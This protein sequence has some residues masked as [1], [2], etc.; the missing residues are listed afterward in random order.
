VGWND[1]ITQETLNKFR[2]CSFRTLR[3]IRVKFGG[4][5]KNLND[6]VFYNRHV[7]PKIPTTAN[8]KALQKYLRD[9][10]EDSISHKGDIKILI[11]AILHGYDVHQGVT[12][13]STD[14]FLT[15]HTNKGTI[16]EAIVKFYPDHPGFEIKGLD[17]IV[18]QTTFTNF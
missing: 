2:G 4:L 6:P 18:I 14:H 13:R 1:E 9:E 16:Q 3:S 10:M 15:N 5:I 11:N 8:C 17:D 7:M 12:F